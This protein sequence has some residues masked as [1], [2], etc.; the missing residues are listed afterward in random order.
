[1]CTRYIAPDAGDIE[2]HW[3]IGSRHAPGWPREMFPRYQGPFIRARRAAPA[4][5]AE[6][7]S[8]SAA[9]GEQAELV[10]GQWSLVPWFAKTPK[11]PYP[12]SNARSEELAAKASYKQPWA[13]GQRCIV[14]AES[15]FEPN[16]ESGRHVPWRF[17][18][19]DGRPWGLAGLWNTWL[20]RETGELLESYTLLTLN[21]DQHPLM[22][23][24]HRPD[25]QRPPE[26]QDKRSVVPIED[27]DLATWL[28]APQAEAAQLLRLAPPE[29]FRAEPAA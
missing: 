6:A 3:H 15:F 29:R 23:R 7:A 9:A 17:W 14:P 20:D 22:R 18:R 12:T 26:A 5:G 24:M 19:A 10:L 27:A 1:M 2:R 21:A 13:R 8:A 28:H 4:A 11:L 25:P 16:W